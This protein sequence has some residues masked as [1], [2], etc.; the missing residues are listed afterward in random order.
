MKKGKNRQGN[1]KCGGICAKYVKSIQIL[2]AH[3]I[4]YLL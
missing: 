1:V 4:F 2:F 3:D